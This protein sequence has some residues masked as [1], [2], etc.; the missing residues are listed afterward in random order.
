MTYIVMT[1]IVMT[2]RVIVY[3]VMTYIVM[4][5]SVRNAC[6]IVCPYAWPH[7]RTYTCVHAWIVIQ[8]MLSRADAS[9]AAMLADAKPQRY[10]R[11]WYFACTRVRRRACLCACA[12]V[13]VFVRACV[14]ACV[15][16]RACVRA[17]MRACVLV[18]DDACD[19]VRPVVCA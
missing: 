15:C 3:I 18:C 14:H 5:A 11:K 4:A 17:C 10:I 13:H 8:E 19:C 1:Y 9:L 12:C 2:Y 6:L 7:T 16:V